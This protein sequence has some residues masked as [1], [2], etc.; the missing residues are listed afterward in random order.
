MSSRLTPVDKAKYS[1]LIPIGPIEDEDDIKYLFH[2]AD[3]LEDEV[4]L[5]R[6]LL[7]KITKAP[8][9]R[10]RQD[11][12]WTLQMALACA[13]VD[14]HKMAAIRAL[15][16]ARQQSDLFAVDTYLRGWQRAE[17]MIKALNL[18]ISHGPEAALRALSLAR[19]NGDLF[20]SSA[21]NRT[22]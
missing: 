15:S 7:E 11:R 19:V 6:S 10:K 12:L 17:N 1:A 8:E 3:V 21:E 14:A 2:R 5:T 4:C 13:D 9:F 20:D 16:L 22:Q 18:E